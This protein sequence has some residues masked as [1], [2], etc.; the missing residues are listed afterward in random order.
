M[1]HGHVSETRLHEILETGRPDA[2]LD[3]CDACRRRLADLR[4]FTGAVL[5]MEDAAFARAFPEGRI[6][7]SRQHVLAAID[8]QRAARVVPFPGAVQP[9]APSLRA[10]PRWMAAAAAGLIIG[11]ALGRWTQ[12]GTPV[13]PST[14]SAPTISASV[15]PAVFVRGEDDLLNAIESVRQ[16]P[17]SQLRSL[18]ELTPLAEQYDT[19]WQAIP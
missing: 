18:H 15:Q 17:I 6:S 3:A 13:R 9:S 10:R 5:S 12:T 11:L 14:A 1:G 4:E 7:T 19:A 2:H 16:G 8:A